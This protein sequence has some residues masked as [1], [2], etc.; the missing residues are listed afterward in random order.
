MNLLN[1]YESML[2]AKKKGGKTAFQ[3]LQ[4]QIADYKYLFIASM[5]ICISI[6]FLVNRYTKPIYLVTTSVLIK[7]KTGIAND[8]KN[9][10]YGNEQN[11]NSNEQD[12][13]EEVTIL[14]SFPFIRRAVDSLDV[15]VGYFGEA[16]LGLIEI[17]KEAPFKV[18]FPNTDAYP[19]LVNK[20]FRITFLD[21]NH[22]RLIE[23]DKST[24]T[25]DKKLEVNK[26]FIINGCPL[27]VKVTDN[28]SSEN[29][30]NKAYQFHTYDLDDVAWD[31]KNRLNIRSGTAE[32]S[33]INIY[34]ETSV[35]QKGIDFLNEFTQQY[36]TYKYEEKSRAISQSL[37]FIDDQLSSIS[38]AL[39]HTES[40]LSGFKTSNSFSDASKMNDRSIDEISQLEKERASLIIHERYFNS[41]SSRLQDNKDL[42]RLVTPSAVGINDNAT[43]NLMKELVTLQIEKNNF[44]SDGTSKNP[45][46]KDLD[47]KIS[48]IK[49]TVKKN[50]S[51]LAENNRARLRQ[52]N[53][54]NNEHRSIVANLPKA[55]RKFVDIKRENDLNEQIYLFLSQKKLEAGILK[56]STTVAN[57]VIESAVL[58]SSIPLKPK[59]SNNYAL[60]LLI[61]M[62]IPFGFIWSKGVLNKKVS[63]KDDY[64]SITNL[65]VIGSIYH[66]SNPSPLV[67]SPSSRTEI[68][69]S[70]RI[71]RSYLISYKGSKYKK[72]ILI[73]SM[74]SGEGKSFCAI[75]IATSLALLKKKTLLVNLD[76]R[77]T[78]ELYGNFEQGLGISAYL[79]DLISVGEMITA[80]DH[81][82]LD[83]VSSGDWPSNST[84][85][86]SDEKLECLIMLLK[87]KYDYI[88]IDSAPIGIIADTL[89]IAQYTD[90]NIAVVRNNYSQKE[91]LSE[92]DKICSEG[93]LLNVSVVF[94]DEKLQNGLR[95]NSYYFGNNN[96]RKANKFKL[97]KLF[98]YPL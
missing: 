25:V 24:G 16:Q 33:V 60:S 59:K 89:L 15:R 75:N 31:F 1:G 22:F 48:T 50:I 94:N 5:A 76:L 79:D 55:E 4:K 7:E 2:P 23:E 77:T 84:E 26:P 72:A 66:S 9:L 80:T 87:E 81:P 47:A 12:I 34:L 91:K 69:E 93:K 71:L 56:A 10:L 35:P 21:N 65:P 53:S 41:I 30:V 28:F 18:L 8:T 36:I 17:Y 64:N 11:A 67:V 37:A 70:F 14:R 61:G 78:S 44:S 68:A 32:G 29:N 85:L 20:K 98:R 42:D 73:T 49:N 57:R 92:L 88:I 43:D 19:K 63:G 97:S 90:L 3:I 82:F 45:L 96:R 58:D 95:S 40:N 54:K 52:I 46:L 27:V 83:Y 38:K 62:A 74:D 13:Q 51:S 39:G 6:A 86:L